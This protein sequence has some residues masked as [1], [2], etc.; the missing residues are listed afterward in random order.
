MANKIKIDNN[1]L[2]QNAS[3]LNK[4]TRKISSLETQL[5]GL[6]WQT[7]NLDIWKLMHS[8]VIYN[9]RKKLKKTVTAIM[10]VAGDFEALERSINSG[11]LLL[12][13]L[14]TI[15]DSKRNSIIQRIYNGIKNAIDK[16]GA[17]IKKNAAELKS[18]IADYIKND[19]AVY[20]Q[21]GCCR[22]IGAASVSSVIENHGS[23]SEN[24]VSNEDTVSLPE[25]ENEVSN[26]YDNLKNYSY[27]NQNY[28]VLQG[29]DQKYCYNQNDYERFWS[30]TYNDNVGC[31]ATA[32]AIAYSIFHNEEVSPNEMGWGSNGAKWNHSKIIEGTK[33][34]SAAETYKTIYD[35][36]KNGTPVMF[37]VRNAEKR[38]YGHHLTAVGIRDGADPDNLGPTDI[39][40]VDPEKGKIESLADYTKGSYNKNTI[41][42]DDGWSLRVPI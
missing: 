24:T 22:I 17:A 26:E 42:D 15:A 5:S 36:V 11:G 6:Y 32:E 16:V 30:N 37:R 41:I 3:R 31:T 2:K 40:V 20:S 33:D 14:E 23:D 10:A 25:T 35:N 27:G 29:L 13:G 1:N 12:N 4:I 38:N 7:G 39:L 9:D 18:R 19:E 34:C 28:F 8:N 21:V